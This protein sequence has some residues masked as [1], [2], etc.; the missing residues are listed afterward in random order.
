MKDRNRVEGGPAQIRDRS[1]LL[2]AAAQQ[3]QAS[4]PVSG[5]G[6]VV[7]VTVTD[8][9]VL[10]SDVP[11]PTIDDVGKVLVRRGSG[12]AWEPVRT[13]EQNL[14][15]VYGT[16]LREPSGRL[17]VT[18]DAPSTWVRVVPGATQDDAL[19][20]PLL[21]VAF[22]FVAGPRKVTF[23]QKE[24]AVTLTG[25][26]LRSHLNALTSSEDLDATWNIL[27]FLIIPFT[28]TGQVLDVQ[29]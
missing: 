2:A 1:R 24:F 10:V 7:P 3:A 29:P 26:T 18:L 20:A 27:R 6:Q 14:L 11:T 12:A 21:D 4:T 13:V 9:T 23:E 17:A 5:G 25:S 19:A 22:S 16:I 28:L 15:P 8:M